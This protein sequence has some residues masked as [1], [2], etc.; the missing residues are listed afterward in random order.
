MVKE[1]GSTDA[2]HGTRAT[3]CATQ[4]NGR[5]CGAGHFVLGITA[6]ERYAR[7]TSTVMPSDAQLLMGITS[8]TL[9]GV[10]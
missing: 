2:E 5:P 3:N 9:F 7:A 8:F 1:A 6:V 10:G 4:Q